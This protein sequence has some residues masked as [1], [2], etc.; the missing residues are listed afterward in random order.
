M[1]KRILKFLTILLSLVTV[2][3]IVAER[4]GVWDRCLGLDQV[5]DVASGFET[6]Y[7]AGVERVVRPGDPAWIPLIDLIHRYSPAELLVDRQPRLLGR[8]V[9]VASAKID[10]GPGGIAEWTA[11]STPIILLYVDWP[12]TTVYP[13][14]YRIVGTIGNLREWVD[15]R[16]SDFHFFTRDVLL[17]LMGIAIALILWFMDREG[18]ALRK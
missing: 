10:L 17:S 1:A 4:F 5:L 16:R 3:F 13:A 12:G 14:D 8:H 15:K 11:P 9:A 2:V 18:P 6:S 7:K